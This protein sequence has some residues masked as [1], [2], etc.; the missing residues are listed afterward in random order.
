M[1][2]E[3]SLVAIH[4]DHDHFIVAAPTLDYDQKLHLSSI[5]ATLSDD[6]ADYESP[7]QYDCLQS[8]MDTVKEETGLDL[9]P[10]GV[11]LELWIQ[12]RPEHTYCRRAEYER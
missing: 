6:C 1:N 10:V 2:S 11:E 12:N 5:A 8:F 4:I 9:L 3:K 7:D